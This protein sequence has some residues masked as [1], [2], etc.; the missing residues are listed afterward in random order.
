[1][2]SSKK[3][4]QSHNSNPEAFK[5]TSVVNTLFPHFHPQS[6]KLAKSWT[7]KNKLPTTPSFVVQMRVVP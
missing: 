3:G 4:A 7:E 1:M 6:G 2:A 5:P